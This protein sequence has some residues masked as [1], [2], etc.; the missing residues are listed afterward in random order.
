MRC[1]HVSICTHYLLCWSTD[2]S[3]W[4]LLSSF[5]PLIDN[6]VSWWLNH[7]I[8]LLE[9]EYS[10]QMEWLHKSGIAASHTHLPGWSAPATLV[11][12]P[13]FCR[14]ALF[15]SG[16]QPKDGHMF[17]RQMS[18]FPASGS[19]QMSGL[20][21]CRDIFGDWDCSLNAAES[22]ANLPFRR[23]RM[24]RFPHMSRLPQRGT[25]FGVRCGC[26]LVW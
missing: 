19:W 11:M 1:S 3:T 7:N 23:V 18:I 14:M 8:S 10:R 21:W 13:P 17:W 2:I 25:V 22:M 9:V 20:P 12:V 24:Q 16:T 5:F 15:T 6:A 26:W 4:S